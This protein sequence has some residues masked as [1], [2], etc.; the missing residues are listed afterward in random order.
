[1]RVNQWHPEE[2]GMTDTLLNTKKLPQFLHVNNKFKKQYEVI[3]KAYN[4]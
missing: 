2:I 1:M 4:K 3:D